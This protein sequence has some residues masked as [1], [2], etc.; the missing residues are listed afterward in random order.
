[1]LL[2]VSTAAWLVLLFFAPG[3]TAAM[4][5]ALT[6][7]PLLAGAYLGLFLHD[8]VGRRGQ[9]GLL[10]ALILAT[11]IAAMGLALAL[12]AVSPW[13]VAWVVVLFALA[14][15]IA[16]IS[17]PL[18]GVPLVVVTILAV[19]LL[20]GLC[21]F[22]LPEPMAFPPT[23]DAL[24]R[25]NWWDDKGRCEPLF[26]SEHRNWV[27]ERLREEDLSAEVRVLH[28]GDSM[29]DGALGGDF[30]S[31]V[32]LLS[33]RREHTRHF[34]IGTGGTAA[35][36]H[37]AAIQT[38]LPIAKPALVV[39]YVFDNDLYE[40]DMPLA[41]CGGEAPFVREGG[42]LRRR[43]LTEDWRLSRASFLSA[44]APLFWRQ[45]ARVSVTARHVLDAFATATSSVRSMTAS[46]DALRE[47]IVAARVHLEAH[48]VGHMVVVIPYR[49][50]I[51]EALATRSDQPHSGHVLLLDTV[52]RGG[53][54]PL[55]GWA[56]VLDAARRRLPQ[57]WTERGGPRD[58]HF[59]VAGHRLFA[60]WL[61][62]QIERMLDA[63]AAAN[64]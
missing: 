30:R 33:R 22:F 57:L 28:V 31:F 40:V 55:D 56:I 64:R 38:T 54:E 16:T 47:Y 19:F 48:G 51:E 60:D 26:P 53:I 9:F 29:V 6:V 1:M 18:P 41:C 36:H 45:A 34:N 52:R 21:R 27:R 24:L 8:S 35:D 42:E 4:A 50:H 20:E 3:S 23:E 5:A 49:A 11:P 25:S 7:G 62:P 12:Y 61:G 13:D 37:L 44:R 43:C 46:P 58:P 17:G 10:L 15:A 14:T 32:D 59:D 2:K 39:Q 63:S